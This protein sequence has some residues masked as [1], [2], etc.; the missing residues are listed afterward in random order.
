MTD[1]GRT[2]STESGESRP[3]W[4]KDAQEALDKTGDAVRTAWETTRESRMSALEAAKKAARELGDA[5]E[6]GIEAA[7]ERWDAE[8]AE[9]PGDVGTS[10][11]TPGTEAPPVSPTNPPGE[12]P[13]ERPI[14]DFPPEEDANQP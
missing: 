13:A 4:I 10:E 7:K 3:K 1:E 11:T 9:T 2:E 8:T 5:L 14:G 12:P 6:K